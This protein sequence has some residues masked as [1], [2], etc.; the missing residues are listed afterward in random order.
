M[1]RT[2]TSRRYDAEQV[3]RFS[4][5]TIAYYDRFARAFWNGTRDHDV[6]QNYVAFLNAI[7]GEPL[8]LSL[9]LVVDPAGISVTSDPWGTK[10]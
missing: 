5:T 8:I 4:D 10:P 9:I 1:S 2:S 6:S 3:R 7:E